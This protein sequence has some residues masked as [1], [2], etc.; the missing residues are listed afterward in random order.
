MQ[1]SL[2]PINRMTM[3]PSIQVTFKSGKELK[4]AECINVDLLNL[5]TCRIIVALI[6]DQLDKP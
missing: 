4:Q 3:D 1:T 2:S 5:F 6:H